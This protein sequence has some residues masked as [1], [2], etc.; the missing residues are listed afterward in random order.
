[1]SQQMHDILSKYLPEHSIAPV[2]ELIKLNHAHL[3]IVNDRKTRHGD[4][5]KTPYEQHLITVNG[6][7]NP[8]RF[9]ITLIH[10]LAH[11]VAFEKYG[12]AIKPHGNEWKYTF[13]QLMLPFINPQIFPSEVLPYLARHFRNPAA[14]T[15]RDTDLIRVLS[16]Y[17]KVPSQK[18]WVESLDHGSIF[19]IGDG[20]YFKKGEKR[21]KR[22]V[23]EDI[24]NGKKYLFPPHAEV[25]LIR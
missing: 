17:D 22:F 21:V 5:R 19:S 23:C 13:Q 8:Y 15:D 16:T 9:L 14:S 18:T 3:K 10:E 6:G 20:R 11:L 7:L 2:I 24:K 25:T 1:M 4:Y 12:R